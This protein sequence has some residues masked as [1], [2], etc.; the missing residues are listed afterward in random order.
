M[1]RVI[2]DAANG[3]TTPSAG[4][5]PDEKGVLIIPDIPANAGGVHVSH[6]E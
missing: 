1:A 2:A 5:V 6:V 4:Y 3:P